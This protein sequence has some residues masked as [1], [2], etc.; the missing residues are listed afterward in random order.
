M[1]TSHEIPN[2]LYNGSIY[3]ELEIYCMIIGRGEGGSY[4]IAFERER[5]TYDICSI[6]IA[7]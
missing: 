6:I 1:V 2:K 5:G 3:L 4:P 7:L